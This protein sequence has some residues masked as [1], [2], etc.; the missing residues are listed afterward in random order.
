V[1]LLLEL[2]LLLGP[3]PRFK[4]PSNLSIKERNTLYKRVVNR[5][6]LPLVVMASALISQF[7]LLAPSYA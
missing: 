5:L 1:I 7:S 2:L 6:L 4:P 3:A